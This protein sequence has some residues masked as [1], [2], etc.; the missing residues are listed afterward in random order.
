MGG[1]AAITDPTE[2]CKAAARFTLASGSA[3]V[4]HSGCSV[5]APPHGR[6]LLSVSEGVADLAR[7]R[8]R[9]S[10]EPGAGWDD[11]FDA[12]LERFPWLDDDGDDDGED[13]QAFSVYAGTARYFGHDGNWF[14]AAKGDPGAAQR[15]PNDPLWIVEALAVV[16]GV[17]RPRTGRELLRGASCR[18]AAFI[19]DP[20]TH[21]TELEPPGPHPLMGRISD[22]AGGL[23]HRLTG[24]IWISDEG[25][26]HRASWTRIVARRPR[27]PFTAPRSR[28]WQTIELWDFGV[29]A[30][31]ELPSPQP[32]EKA[33]IGDVLAGI[34]WLWRRKRAY[35]RR[36]R[37]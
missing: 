9:V 2:W 20:L 4:W 17:S 14:Q 18:R 29:E 6:S 15:S 25:R 35:E 16:D 32:E 28:L 23:S 12:L 11:L 26:I 31:I 1:D 33:R 10:V 22:A 37:M 24:E 3:R 30:D 5:P 8:L 13:P 7:R 19:V 36:A 21:A 34:G 27:W